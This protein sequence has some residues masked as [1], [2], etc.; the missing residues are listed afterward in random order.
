MKAFRKLLQRT[1]LYGAYKALG[2]YPDYWYWKLRGQPI[3]SPHLLKQHTVRDH[4][5]RFGLRTL[6]E[7]QDW[8]RDL[9]HS[10]DAAQRQVAVVRE[11]AFPDILTDAY[12]VAYPFTTSLH[13]GP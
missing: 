7:E 13:S 10:L 11:V 5:E 3:R 1:P 6:V 9:L 4:A 12:R 2:H 8:A